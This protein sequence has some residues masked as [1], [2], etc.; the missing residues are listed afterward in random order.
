MLGKLLS[1]LAVLHTVSSG[2]IINELNADNPQSDDTEYIELYNTDNSVVALDTYTIVLYNGATDTAYDVI[3]LTGKSI[4]AMGYFVIG[5]N[6]VVPTPDFVLPQDSNL[7]QNGPDGV[8]LYNGN[9][10]SFSVGMDVTSGGLVDAIVYSRYTGRPADGL[11]ATLLPGQSIV[12]EDE[13]F[14]ILDESLSRC[15][16]TDA[17]NTAQFNTSYATPG[18]ANNCTLPPGA[19]VPPPATVPATT[20]MSG[21]TS[22]PIPDV[23]ISELNADNPGVD[24]QEYLELR[25]KG[26]VTVSL[27]NFVVVFYNGANNQAYYIQDLSSY[28]IPARGYFTIGSANV[29]PRP[30]IVTTGLTIQNGPDAV[31]LYFGNPSDF[32]ISMTVT[33]TNL[34]DVL[35]YSKRAGDTVAGLSDVLA[36]GQQ[37]VVENEQAVAEDE[38]I[39][40]CGGLDANTLSQ[41][42][43]TYATPGGENNCAPLPTLNPTTVTMA[44]TTMPSPTTTLSTTA[45]NVVINEVNADNPGTDDQEYV[46]LLNKDSTS[47]NLNGLVLVY[48]NGADDRAYAV[49]D[50]SG[51]T[52]PSNG[53]YTVG[54]SNVVPLPNVVSDATIQNGP[55]AVALYYGNADD[56]IIGMTASRANLVDVVLYATR[57]GSTADSLLA[58]LAP[59]QQIV[60]ENAGGTDIDVSASRCGGL[61]PVMLSEF[62]ATRPTPGGENN[63]APLPT[64]APTTP[65]IVPS[66]IINELNSD[67]PGIDTEEYVEL[68]NKG[69]SNV[70]LSDFQLVFYN[71]ADNL[72]YLIIQLTGSIPANG[73]FTI[74]ST[75]VTPT[76][77]LVFTNAENVI[78]NGI[79]AVAL[80]YQRSD[81]AV[82]ATVS[83]VGLVDALVHTKYA[84]P[85]ESA[86]IDALTPGQQPALELAYITA[87][88]AS[89]GRCSGQ[90]PL[91]LAQFRMTVPTPGTSNNCNPL[92]TLPPR[93]TTQTPPV[94][95]IIINEMNADSPSVDDHE[96]IELYNK[97]NSDVPLDYFVLVLYNGNTN[98]AYRVLSFNGL[99]LTIPRQGYFVIGTR[100]TNPD[101]EVGNNS[102]QNGPDAIALYY[103][104]AS[105]YSPG[106]DVTSDGLVDVVVYVNSGGDS[107]AGLTAALTPGQPPLHEDSRV[108]EL[109]E[110][111]GRCTGNSPIT[112]SQF[113]VMLPT[114]GQPNDCSPVPTSAT[115]PAPAVVLNELNAD[116]PGTDNR[117]YIELF[118]TESVTVRLDNVVLVFYNGHDNAAYT[119]IDLSRNSI[120]A[121]GYFVVG[122]PNV[123]PSPDVV[124]MD[125]QNILQNGVDAVGLY[126][127]SPSQFVIGMQATGV[128]LIDAI[129]YSR[130]YNDTNPQLISALT[131]GESVLHEDDREFQMDETLSR[132][133]GMTPFQLTLWQVAPPSPG[134]ENRCAPPIII[135]EVNADNP[136]VDDQEFIELYNFDSTRAHPLD[137]M[138]LVLYD[139][140]SNLRAYDV[141]ELTGARAIEPNG[142]FVI[143]SG[144]VS[145]RPDLVLPTGQNIL[146]NGPDAVAMYHNHNQV[147][148]LYTVGMAPTNAFLVDVLVY[149]RD[150]RPTELIT[151]L[152]PGQEVVLESSTVSDVSVSRCGGN[153]R[154]TLSQFRS[155]YHTPGGP[156][157]CAPLPTL[158]P[159]TGSAATA[160]TVSPMGLVI[161]EV[162]AD[163]PS[164]DTAEFIELYNP[165]KLRV[166]L[167]GVFLVLYNGATDLA[168]N[169]IQLSGNEVAPESVFVIGSAAV[170]PRPDLVLEKNENILQNGED[171]VALYYNPGGRYYGGMTVTA[172]NLLDA[173]VYSTSYWNGSNL[174]LNTLTPGQQALHEY[175][176]HNPD[177]MDESLSRCKGVDPKTLSQFVLAYPTPGDKN[178][179]EDLPNNDKYSSG[180]S[181]G[182][183]AGVVIAVLVILGVIAAAGFVLFR[184][185]KATT[186]FAAKAESGIAYNN[187]RPDDAVKVTGLPVAYDGFDNVLY[188]FEHGDNLNKVSNETDS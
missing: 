112:L 23:V 125:S 109:D 114:P 7:F 128:D 32:T 165:A 117:E 14:D 182:G 78:H 36:P 177:D 18:A 89:L 108:L 153:D 123:T 122:S 98:T 25:N 51:G 146:Q 84:P 159:P 167:D 66:I 181:S 29:N 67:T 143:G 134:R 76:P 137:R 157:N 3:Y 4:P 35:I 48:Y 64:M 49:I 164:Y 144:N 139:G 31:A 106:M 142:Y 82:G 42:R 19:T 37:L 21:A 22:N 16:G 6:N 136:G 161:N 132:C 173:V 176:R 54:S 68:Y 163:N 140:S 115:N 83:S 130:Q 87:G 127:G 172:E 102:I 70:D 162:N 171:G 60:Y 27:R 97:E 169:V 188:N 135:S 73:Y 105:R 44:T 120:P 158:P 92:A 129:V 5:S 155:T 178:N 33:N 179:C 133:G 45:P 9:P 17:L 94:S 141:I 99:G 1:L 126:F 187:M 62:Q 81:I 50:L 2:V 10:G 96:Y 53:Y 56:Y 175:S 111:I 30:D 40:R 107:G 11:I 12:V 39:S 110:S 46:E 85:S 138:V 166:S 156:N 160:A 168:Y 52:I 147:S 186:E 65:T 131:P 80:H 149:A 118:N 152:A 151:R 180:L 183:V 28:S 103:G 75:N 72:A 121:R 90:D 113:R 41:F 61:N 24:D 91:S 100:N 63:C 55:D 119:V 174:I 184:R 116:N 95:Q 104:D 86:L 58:T 74:G 43:V 34:R 124:L 148:D 26:S 15:G 93:T 154:I 71:G 145:P 101:F 8:A 57:T 150:N 170:D 20:P 47:V 77:N 38:S 88:D 13:N 79:D 69:S 185:K 59:G